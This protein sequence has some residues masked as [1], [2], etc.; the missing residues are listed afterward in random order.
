MIQNNMY[1]AEFTGVAQVESIFYDTEEGFLDGKNPNFCQ[2]YPVIVME[3][4][5]GGD[6]F[7]HIGE[8]VNKRE[9]IS[10]KYLA[11]MFRSVVEALEGIHKKKFIH[12][13]L[14][15]EN[16]LLL[17]NTKKNPGVKVIDFGH[18]VRVDEQDQ[19]YVGMSLHGSPGCYAPESILRKE[20]SSKSDIWQAGCILY[21]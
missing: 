20:Y 18:M 3:H 17:S 9:N 14:K 15:T 7:A 6:L 11:K 5:S 4:I 16:V 12:R 2:S 1:D 10:E 19:L 13:D 8:R 21:T